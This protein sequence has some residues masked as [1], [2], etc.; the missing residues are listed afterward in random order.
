[1]SASTVYCHVLSGNVTVVTDLDGNVTNVVCPEFYRI[2]HACQ[3][4]RG[5]SGF[6]ANVL[7]VV[8][9]KATDSRVHYCEFGDPNHFLGNR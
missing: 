9:D 3:K 1:M 2:T 5:D 7:K 6:F 8:V 4:K